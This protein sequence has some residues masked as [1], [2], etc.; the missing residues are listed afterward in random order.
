MHERNR[1]C[2]PRGDSFV[3]GLL[4]PPDGTPGP[5]Y[6]LEYLARICVMLHNYGLCMTGEGISLEASIQFIEVNLASAGTG[7]GSK[8]Q[9]PA[10]APR[11]RAG[12]LEEVA[13]WWTCPESGSPVATALGLQVSSRTDNGLF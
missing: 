10:P 2:I 13:D 3:R 6:A 9:T 12:Y 5:T 4:E 8:M 11:E 7:R 1:K